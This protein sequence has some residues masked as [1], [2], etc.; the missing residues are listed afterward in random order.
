[1]HA[2]ELTKLPL[3]KQLLLFP[4]LPLLLR[5]EGLVRRDKPWLQ[6]VSNQLVGGQPWVDG[7]FSRFDFLNGYYCK[8]SRSS[9]IAVPSIIFS[10]CLYFQ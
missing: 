9:S 7:D 10:T 3:T 1:M 5:S 4:F 2:S 8:S 6:F